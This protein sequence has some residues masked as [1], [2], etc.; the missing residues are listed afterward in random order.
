MPINEVVILNADT[1]ELEQ[2]PEDMEVFPSKVSARLKR[3]LQQTERALDNYVSSQF[4]KALAD[5]MGGY[6]DALKFTETP[7]VSLYCNGSEVVSM[8][9][10]SCKI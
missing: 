3:K 6:R 1:N 5:L 4:L 2:P 8:F 9:Q 7:E 10:I